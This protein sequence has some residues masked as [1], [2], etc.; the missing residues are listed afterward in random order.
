MEKRRKKEKLHTHHE[1]KSEKTHLSLRRASMQFAPLIQTLQAKGVLQGPMATLLA[2]DCKPCLL[3]LRVGIA[4][5]DRVE[6]KKGRAGCSRLWSSQKGDRRG[7]QGVS[8]VLNQ[9]LKSRN[10][11]IQRWGPFKKPH[12]HKQIL[13]L[14]GTL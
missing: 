6:S 9:L 8:P 4:W 1:K 10:K 13:K 7:N 12:T 3:P 5:F 2:L 14:R 11:H